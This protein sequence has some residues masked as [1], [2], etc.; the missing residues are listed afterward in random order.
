[1]IDLS[2]ISLFNLDAVSKQVHYFFKFLGHAD[3]PI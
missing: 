1:V 3:T 2:A